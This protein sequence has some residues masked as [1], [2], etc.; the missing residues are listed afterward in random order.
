M[1]SEMCIRDRFCGDG[2]GT[3]TKLVISDIVG[4]FLL[5]KTIISIYND[6]LIETSS[7]FVAL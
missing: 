2:L 5:V 4:G 3:K 7:S 6:N 1:G